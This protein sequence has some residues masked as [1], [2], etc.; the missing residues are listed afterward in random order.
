LNNHQR[1]IR[2]QRRDSIRFDV[3]GDIL[4][5]TGL[6]GLTDRELR[7]AVAAVGPIAADVAAYLGQPLEGDNHGDWSQHLG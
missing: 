2:L 7:D 1:I 5:W 3:P 4:Y 6:W